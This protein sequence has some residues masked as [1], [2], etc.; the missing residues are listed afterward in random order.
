MATQKAKQPAARSTKPKT[1]EEYLDAA[2]KERRAAL[3]RLRE[4]IKRAAPKAT[5]S[6]SYGM[7]GFKHKGRPLMLFAYWKDHFAV[8]GS[9]DAHAAE[10]E[11]YDQSHKG[12]IRFPTDEPLPYALLT[13]MVKARVAEIDRSG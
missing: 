13:K 10:L 11:N 9:F 4:T 12:T 6:F 2:P 8:Y 1:V 7:V 5:E 3:V